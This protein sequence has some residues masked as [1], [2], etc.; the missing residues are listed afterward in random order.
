MQGIQL[1]A[2]QGITSILK[3]SEQSHERNQPDFCE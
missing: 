2:L 1:L 3:L